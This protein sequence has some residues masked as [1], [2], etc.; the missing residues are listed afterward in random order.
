MVNQAI[1]GRLVVGYRELDDTVMATTTDVPLSSTIMKLVWKPSKPLV[2]LMVGVP[3]P[4][5]W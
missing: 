1:S 2:A 3:T 4:G 5:I